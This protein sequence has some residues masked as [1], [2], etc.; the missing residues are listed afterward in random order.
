MNKFPIFLQHSLHP[1]KNFISFRNMKNIFNFHLKVSNQ[2]SVQFCNKF[3]IFEI[4]QCPVGPFLGARFMGT[5]HATKKPTPN[6]PDNQRT[7]ESRLSIQTFMQNK[8]RFGPIK[9]AS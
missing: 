1:S 8:A 3:P 5:S 2:C 7:L 4:N 9:L 6:I